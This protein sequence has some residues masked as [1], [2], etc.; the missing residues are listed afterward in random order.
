MSSAKKYINICPFL[1]KAAQCTETTTKEPERRPFIISDNIPQLPATN[2]TDSD[3]LTPQDSVEDLADTTDKF[4]RTPDKTNTTDEDTGANIE[5]RGL[6]NHLTKTYPIRSKPA[7]RQINGLKML[8]NNYDADTA[9]DST[10]QDR[11]Q[12]SPYDQNRGRQLYQRDYQQFDAQAN[13]GSG[14]NEDSFG[15]NSLLFSRNRNKQLNQALPRQGSVTTEKTPLNLS[16]RRIDQQDIAVGNRGIL[17]SANQPVGDSNRGRQYNEQRYPQLY[18]QDR[19]ASDVGDKGSTG[20]INQPI[21]DNFRQRQY[22]KQGYQQLNNQDKFPFDVNRIASKN[23]QTNQENIFSTST[24]EGNDILG[25]PSLPFAR[26]TPYKSDSATCDRNGVCNTVTQ[27]DV[28][29]STYKLIEQFSSDQY[30]TKMCF[31]EIIYVTEIDFSDMLLI[32][33]DF[34]WTI[35]TTGNTNTLDDA[36]CSNFLGA[37]N[38]PPMEL[39]NIEQ[40]EGR[41]VKEYRIKHCG[42]GNMF[43]HEYSSWPNND[44]RMIQVTISNSSLLQCQRQ[45]DRDVGEQMYSTT[46][47][48]LTYRSTFEENKNTYV[49]EMP[50]PSSVELTTS[51]PGGTIDATRIT[52]GPPVVQAQRGVVETSDSSRENYEDDLKDYMRIIID[53]VMKNKNFKGMCPHS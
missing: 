6:F 9:Q 38:N 47:N 32:S 42:A 30:E 19:F 17:E 35:E 13:Y 16:N 39:A 14:G 24:R 1:I 44:K 53:C 22:N 37:I 12:R 4:E 43:K 28:F 36:S 20:S 48:P 7:Y 18:N 52:P 33:R 29:Q 25:A 46:L 49:T 23:R 51:S 15:T 41:T 2:E 45:Q 3:T 10:T 31:T 27:K 11:Y 26:H 40:L 34:V 50:R 8:M 21:G 5:E